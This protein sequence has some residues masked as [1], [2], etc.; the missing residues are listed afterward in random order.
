VGVDRAGGVSGL[1]AGGWPAPSAAVAARLRPSLQPAATP[2]RLG[3]GR[4]RGG[5]VAVTAGQP[6][7]GQPSRGE[8][9]RCAWWPHP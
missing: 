4:S 1:D 5:G 9:P 6:S 3:V 8:A 7:E 2:P